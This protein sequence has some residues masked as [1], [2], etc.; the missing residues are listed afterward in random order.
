MATTANAQD[1]LLQYDDLEY[2]EIIEEQPI[3]EERTVQTNSQET[4]H[5]EGPM[6]G[7]K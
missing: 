5:A 7:P 4:T 2:T 6:S 3:Q 1:S